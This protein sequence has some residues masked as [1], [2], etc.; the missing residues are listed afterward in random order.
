MRQ[1]QVYT[2]KLLK[3]EETQKHVEVLHYFEGEIFPRGL[4]LFEI[5]LLKQKRTLSVYYLSSK[6]LTLDYCQ[7]LSYQAR[8]S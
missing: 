8:G 4:K 7:E 6:Q 5:K 1:P 2:C 3:F